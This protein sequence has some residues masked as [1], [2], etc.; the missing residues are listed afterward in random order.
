ME[1]I[2]KITIMNDQDSPIYIKFENDADLNMDPNTTV[3]MDVVEGAE[4]KV[5][6]DHIVTK[7]F[8]RP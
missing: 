2:M 1:K 8:K 4:L 6:S 3:E 5:E 7:N